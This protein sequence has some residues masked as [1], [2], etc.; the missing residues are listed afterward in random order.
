MNESVAADLRRLFDYQR[1]EQ[2]PK[3][4][5][6]I[7]AA[8]DGSSRMALSDDE[9]SFA[10]AGSDMTGAAGER[11]AFCPKCK[12][13]RVFRLYSG[14]RAFCKVCNMEINI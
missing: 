6:V 10:A 9:L 8:S 5:A 11:E 1:F 13:K 7:D 2:D 4:K 12:C 14:G 3:L